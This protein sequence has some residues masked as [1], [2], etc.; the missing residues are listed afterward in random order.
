[1]QKRMILGSKHF[2]I[3]IKRLCHQL[4]ENH[5]DFSGSAIL[6]LQPRG[7]FVARRIQKQLQQILNKGNILCGDLDITFFRDDYRRREMVIPSTTQI[8]FIIENKKVILVDDVLFTGRTIR[9]A[10]DAMVAFGRPAKVELL[11]LVDRRYSRH[12][13]IEPDYVGI[14]VDTVASEK[15]EVHWSET[16]ND[17]SIWLITPDKKHAE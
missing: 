14:A 11:T 4:I 3:T 5:N 13:P 10:M 9:A 12:L 6:G 1:M 15:V 7:I 8:D 17:D 16:D 2:E